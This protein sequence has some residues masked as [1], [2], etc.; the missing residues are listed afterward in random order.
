MSSRSRNARRTDLTSIEFRDVNGWNEGT[1]DEGAVREKNAIG[2]KAVEMWMVIGSPVAESLHGN[3]HA[4]STI[5]LPRHL[6]IECF[7]GPG[8]TSCQQPQE[9]SV[10]QEKRTDAFGYGEGDHAVRDVLE[11]LFPQPLAPESEPFC[12]TARAEHPRLTAEPHEKFCFAGTT[13][14]AGKT[15]L[16]DT[17]LEKVLHCLLHNLSQWA[18]LL[19]IFLLIDHTKPVEVLLEEL[20]EG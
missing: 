7:Y 10:P 6:T 8:C 13:Y 5:M 4:G 12:M 18:E 14:Y 3:H 17:A 19:F 20:V 1:P 11:K 2:D 15:V 9:F 16:E